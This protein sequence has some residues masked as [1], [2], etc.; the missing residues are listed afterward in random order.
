MEVYKTSPISFDKELIKTNYE[1]LK[2]NMIFQS[3]APAPEE[4]VVHKHNRDTASYTY[5]L[6][7]SMGETFLTVVTRVNVM[8]EKCITKKKKIYNTKLCLHFFL[9]L[10][11]Y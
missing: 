9:E 4:I 8:T 10:K 7:S 3:E 5:S 2:P 1:K 11:Y 6:S